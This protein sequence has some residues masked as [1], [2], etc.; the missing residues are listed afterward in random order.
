M[1]EHQ[2]VIIQLFS[3]VFRFRKLSVATSLCQDLSAGEMSLLIALC[4]YNG[5]VERETL[6]VCEISHRLKTTQP[7]ATQLVNRLESKNLVVRKPDTADRRT[8]LVTVTEEG[9]AAFEKEFRR[10]E[11][12]M[13][14]IVERMGADRAQMLLALLDEFADTS[15]KV[16][17]EHRAK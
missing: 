12:A 7:A 6:P 15:T 5:K 8:V 13:G 4:A 17:E 1:A 14:E 9:F 11:E 2:D 16:I 3:T 10:T